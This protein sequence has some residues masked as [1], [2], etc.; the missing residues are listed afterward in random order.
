MRSIELRVKAKAF[1]A[2]A[3]I[4]RSEEY[5]ARNRAWRAKNKD[6]NDWATGEYEL[7]HRLHRHRILHVRRAARS[8]HLAQAFVCGLQYRQIEKECYERPNRDAV[9]RLIKRY[10]T[11]DLRSLSDD[12]LIRATNEWFDRKG[13]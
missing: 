12:D 6:W 5:K 11:P 7:A 10:G 1:T 2:E 13:E 9:R 8:A 4:V 3:K